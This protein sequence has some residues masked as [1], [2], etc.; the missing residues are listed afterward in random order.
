MVHKFYKLCLEKHVSILH[1]TIQIQDQFT[2]LDNL[3]LLVNEISEI[4]ELILAPKS[5]THM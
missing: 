4:S 5:E 2:S 3:I 1:K